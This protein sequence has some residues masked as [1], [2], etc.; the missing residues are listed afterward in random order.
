[1]QSSKM[2]VAHRRL[3][4]LRGLEDEVVEGVADLGLS[5]HSTHAVSK[6]LS[7]KGMRCGDLRVVHTLEPEYA[8]GKW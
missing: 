5:V 8:S 7:I 4:V 6:R 2:R 3:P 1:M